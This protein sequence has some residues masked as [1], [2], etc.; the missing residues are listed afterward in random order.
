MGAFIVPHH[1][2]QQGQGRAIQGNKWGDSL[3]SYRMIEKSRADF[4]L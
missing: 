1:L 2:F 3:Y 4:L